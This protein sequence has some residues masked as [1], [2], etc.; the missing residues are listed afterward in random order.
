MADEQRRNRWEE[1]RDT[2]GKLICRYDAAR[3]II[4]T[5]QRCEKA[6]RASLAPY[7]E[8]VTRE[9]GRS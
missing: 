4:E 3:D 6:R 8:R 2:D 1:V 9:A 5:K 7:R